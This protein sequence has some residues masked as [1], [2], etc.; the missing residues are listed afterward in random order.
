M[1]AKCPIEVHSVALLITTVAF[2]LKREHEVIRHDI[3]RHF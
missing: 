1:Q 3:F 2:Y